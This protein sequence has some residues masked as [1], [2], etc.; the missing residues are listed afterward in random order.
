MAEQKTRPS[1]SS[2]EE[3]IDKIA[4]KKVRDDCF[5]LIRIMQK[6]TNEEPRL[7]GE[8]IVGFGQYHYRY[9][10]GHEGFSCLTGFSPR[11]QNISLYIM[12]GYENRTE[13]TASLGKHKAGKGCLYIKRL[14]DIDI[15]VLEALIRESVAWLKKTYPQSK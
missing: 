5:S 2:A 7:W 11:K 12:P 9:E 6:V 3:F 1:Q 14:D 8:T 15:H 4:D 10:S 13:L